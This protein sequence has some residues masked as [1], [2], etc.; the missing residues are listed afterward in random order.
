MQ[1]LDSN[2]S[3]VCTRER[4][5]TNDCQLLC[6]DWP[7]ESLSSSFRSMHEPRDDGPLGQI[8]PSLA[9]SSAIEIAKAGDS[10]LAMDIVQ[11]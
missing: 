9:I 11:S 4:V 1:L 7:D 5:L 10:R 2:K 6:F 3:Q 8:G